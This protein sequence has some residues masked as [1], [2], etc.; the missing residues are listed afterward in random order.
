[1]ALKSQEPAGQIRELVKWIMEHPGEDLRAET[2]A[3][4]AHM[5]VR[6]FYRAFVQA[7]GM[8]PAEWVEAVRL[9]VAKQL[10]EQ[11]DELAEQIAFK[12]GFA[13]YEQMRRTFAKRLGSSPLAYRGRT[14]GCPHTPQPSSLL[15]VKRPTSL[16]R[17]GNVQATVN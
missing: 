7:T 14:L 9:E 6:N 11:T 3:E 17:A 5:S 15:Q 16:Q 2:L 12:A 10:L 13:N 8:T 4:R 1:M